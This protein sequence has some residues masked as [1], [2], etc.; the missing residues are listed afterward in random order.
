[1]CIVGESARHFSSLQ[2]ENPTEESALHVFSGYFLRA[3]FDALDAG[4]SADAPLSSVFLQVDEQLRLSYNFSPEA[5]FRAGKS[6]TLGKV[7]GLQTLLQ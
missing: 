4:T 2:R 1:M 6:L 3:V 5:E 7:T